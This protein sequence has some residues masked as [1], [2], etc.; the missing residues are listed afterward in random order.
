MGTDESDKDEGIT[1]ANH[2]GNMRFAM[3]TVFTTI[4]GA[5]IAFPFTNEHKVFI[6]SDSLRYLFSFVGLVFSL[7]FGFSQHRISYLV[8]YYQVKALSPKQ[9][10]PDDHKKWKCIANTTML[11]PFITSFLFWLL[12]AYGAFNTA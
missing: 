5:L 7:F 6:S 11:L 2:Y 9:L 3:F 1:L 4:L 10:L 8:D 12:F